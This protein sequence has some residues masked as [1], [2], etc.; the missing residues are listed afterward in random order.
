MNIALLG[1]GLMG[2]PMAHRLLRAGHSLSV[3]ARAPDQA[4]EVVA[5]GAHLA[6]TPAEAVRGAGAIVLML[7][8]AAAIDA[9]LLGPAARA[10]LSGRRVI[11]MGTIGPAESR[12]IAH[13]VEQAGGSYLEAPVL[14]SIPEAERGTLLVM[15]GGSPEDYEASRDLL[16]AFGHDPVYLGAVGSA[17]AA[18]LALNQL[19]ASMTAAFALSLAWVEH[20]G[21]EVDAFMKL[22][23]ESALYAPTF[24]KKLPRLRAR[25]YANPNFPTRHLLKD[26]NLFLR[27]A[28]GLGLGAE[29]LEGVQ[30]RLEV[31]IAR[32]Y[33]DADYSALYEAILRR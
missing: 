2:R 1:T 32:G 13:A 8:D 12:R 4:A 20:S 24:D 25:D 23:R 19:I 30:H 7:S 16:G 18:K 5:A 21:V 27:E 9:V 22:L 17:A 26:V 6:P 31:A 29:A 33:A 11:Q 15:V 28:A 14:G 3:Y 10:E